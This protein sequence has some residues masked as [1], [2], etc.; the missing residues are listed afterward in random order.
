MTKML[1][2]AF[3]MILFVKA[4][5]QDYYIN[6]AAVGDTTV[7]STVK[8]VNLH[9]QFGQGTG[10][11]TVTINGGDVLHLVSWPIGVN[12]QINKGNTMTIYPDPMTEKGSMLKFNSPSSGNTTINI[13]DL[14]GKTLYKK[15]INTL[16]GDNIFHI[17]GLNYGTYIVKVNGKNY[18]Y[19][20]K[21]LSVIGYRDGI[22]VDFVSNA[23]NSNLKSS[24]NE[25]EMT[26]GN[27][28]ILQYKGVSGP[29]GSYIM[30]IPTG[31]KTVTFH[32]Y[33]CVD[34]DGHSYGTIN[35]KKL[36]AGKSPAI[37]TLVFMGENLNVGTQVTMGHGQLNNDT[38]EKNC[39]DDDS[40]N[41]N[42]YGGIYQWNEVMQYTTM[43]GSQGICPDGWHVPT[44]DEFEN[45]IN[46]YA[47]G[48]M[49]AGSNMKEVG[50]AHWYYNADATDST[51]F[52]AL[53]AGGADYYTT[54]S[55]MS[56]HWLTDYWS[57]TQYQYDNTKAYFL[58]LQSTGAGDQYDRKELG[59]SVRCVHN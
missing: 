52:T 23:P 56:L 7:L 18:S 41:C 24:A 44:Y 46:N 8:I 25:V 12:N 40:T 6:F 10:Y 37:D 27:G 4:Q 9:K 38:I 28:N 16:S 49:I 30:D 32:F 19:T 42:I 50:D 39:Y 22:K 45:F 54:H 2:I 14:L 35:I 43:N 5:S 20:G 47:G 13:F 48:F 33:K 53:P 29:F 1:F 36:T 21:L 34:A 31:S 3:L 57:S 11:D 58:Q 51:G 59:L 15:D 26:Y 17:S 55:Y